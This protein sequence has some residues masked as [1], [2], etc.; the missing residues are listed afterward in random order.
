MT[1]PQKLR[2][3]R[4]AQ[5]LSQSQAALKLGVTIDTLQNWE[6]GRH[7]PRPFV[8]RVVLGI[9]DKGLEG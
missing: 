3:W 1:L 5:K 6:Q 8:L 2:A 4:K 7:I 9:V